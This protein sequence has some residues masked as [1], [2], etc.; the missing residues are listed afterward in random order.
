MLKP[1]NQGNFLIRFTFQMHR[2]LGA[3]ETTLPVQHY[4]WKRFLKWF[5]IGRSTWLVLFQL[6]LL[7]YQYGY[8]MGR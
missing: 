8:H 6:N 1:K 4:I 3:D 2:S 5:R 7:C